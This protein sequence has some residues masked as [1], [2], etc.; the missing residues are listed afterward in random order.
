MTT[1]FAHLAG[2][3]PW[4]D[5]TL[6][7]PV[8]VSWSRWRPP[9]SER[10]QVWSPGSKARAL[11][12]RPPD[13]CA[14]VPQQARARAYK[15]GS[16]GPRWLALGRATQAPGSRHQGP[17]ISRRRAAPGLARPLSGKEALAGP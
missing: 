15:G 16:P 6:G 7:A 12:P 11:G 14:R 17:T 5:W 3:Y 10:P 9:A 13:A 1:K 2:F 8:R 4:I